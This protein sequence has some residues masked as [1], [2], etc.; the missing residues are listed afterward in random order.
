MKRLKLIITTNSDF[1]GKLLSL[2][3]MGE[4]IPKGVNII[5]NLLIIYSISLC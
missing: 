2:F 4:T 5:K 1:D 3:A